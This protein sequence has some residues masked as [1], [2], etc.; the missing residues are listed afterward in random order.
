MEWFLLKKAADQEREDIPMP[1]F[2]RI[3]SRDVAQEEK[4]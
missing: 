3:V 4:R 2:L 1:D